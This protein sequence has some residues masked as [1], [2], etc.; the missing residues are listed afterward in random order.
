MG[1]PRTLACDLGTS[2]ASYFTFDVTWSDGAY[3]VLRSSRFAADS[4]RGL[5]VTADGT[6]R[7]DSFEIAPPG[8]AL[9]HGAARTN[10]QLFVF[11][12]RGVPEEPYL[13]VRRVFL[14]PV[15]LDSGPRRQRAA[16]P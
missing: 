15:T 2:S 11:Y 6:M 1:T 14:R 7:G 3:T 16:R 12:D 5:H 10:G 4:L 13:G 8:D 9:R